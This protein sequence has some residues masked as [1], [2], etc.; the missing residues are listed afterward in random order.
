MKIGAVASAHS[1]GLLNVHPDREILPIR[2]VNG[3]SA[4]VFPRKLAEIAETMAVLAGT[5]ATVTNR[6][7]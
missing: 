4:Q 7:G 6:H 2:R 1:W 5:S 3:G